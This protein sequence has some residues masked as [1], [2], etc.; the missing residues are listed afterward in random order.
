MAV[1]RPVTNHGL[2]GVQSKGIGQGRVII[3]GKY[4]LM[5]MKEK[6]KLIRD[7]IQKLT[8]EVEEINKDNQT[9]LTLERKW[10]TLIK[11][12]RSLEGELADRNLAQD[13][14]RSGTKPEDIEAHFYHIKNQND[15]QKAL[16]DKIFGEKRDMESE[17]QNYEGQIQ[18]IQYANEAK[19][20]DLDPEQ[21]N[22]YEQLKDE[23]SHL[24][25]NVN[26]NRQQLE[27]VNSRLI[28]AEGQ[29]AQDKLKQRA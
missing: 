1:D 8:G 22:E 10:D 9:Y 25:K 11:E 2:A 15:K 5:K 28:Q 6:N 14:Q 23:N 19:L 20:N 13:K 27:E 4:H 26:D 7:E 24:Q 3:D 16:L 29:L 12:V 21:R 17:I 18:E